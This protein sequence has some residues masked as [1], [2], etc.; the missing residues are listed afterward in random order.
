[1]QQFATQ[2]P[3]EERT[4]V[5]GSF[6]LGDMHALKLDTLEWVN[7]VINDK[8]ADLARTN[9]WLSRVA[10][11][12]LLVFGGNGHSSMYCN[13]DYFLTITNKI[14]EKGQSKTDI[15]ELEDT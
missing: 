4:S 2:T 10:E 5:K 15:A 6:T 7:I 9:H 13:T 3:I 8:G 14:S 1:M 12:T 11:D